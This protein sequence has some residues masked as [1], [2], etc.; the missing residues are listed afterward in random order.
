MSNME[1]SRN[2]LLVRFFYVF[3]IFGLFYESFESLTDN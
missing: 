1:D 3:I 2:D